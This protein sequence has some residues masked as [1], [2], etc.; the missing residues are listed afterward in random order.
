MGDSTIDMYNCCCGRTIRNRISTIK[1]HYDSTRHRE[2]LQTGRP[3]TFEIDPAYPPGHW[4]R[5]YTAKKRGILK[6]YHTHVK[7]KKKEELG[8]REIEVL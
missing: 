7:Q 8:G 5:Y 4:R 1:A 2:Y 6:Y 3:N